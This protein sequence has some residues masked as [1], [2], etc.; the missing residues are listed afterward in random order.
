M[1]RSRHVLELRELLLLLL[2]GGE[3]SSLSEHNLAAYCKRYIGFINSLRGWDPSLNRFLLD[4]VS[5]NSLRGGIQ[6][7]R[8]SCHSFLKKISSPP[9]KKFVFSSAPQVFEQSLLLFLFQSG[10]AD[11]RSVRQRPGRGV[12][13]DGG[14]SGVHLRL[15]DVQRRQAGGV[16]GKVRRR[17]N[18]KVYERSELFL[19]LLLLRQRF[20]TSTV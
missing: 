19:L 4:F 14:R 6:L 2:W 15:G 13:A 9:K 7:F 12:R 1:R 17:K 16:A 10:R 8:W 20:C 3:G 11:H 18:M 5:T